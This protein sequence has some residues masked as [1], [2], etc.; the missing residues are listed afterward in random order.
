VSD[1][2]V[3]RELKPHYPSQYWKAAYT[4]EKPLTILFEQIAQYGSSKHK[5][6]L[7]S[8][9]I[10]ANAIFS[11]REAFSLGECCLSL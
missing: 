5:F 9:D 11:Y 4:L 1:P 7:I 10:K 2:G 8:Y 6:V 3:L